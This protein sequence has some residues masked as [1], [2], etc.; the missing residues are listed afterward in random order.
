MLEELST[1]ASGA[2]AG[3]SRHS[4]ITSRLNTVAEPWLDKVLSYLPDGCVTCSIA[5]QRPGA[6]GRAAAEGAADDDAA[7]VACGDGGLLVCRC[8]RGQ[9]PVMAVLHPADSDKDNRYV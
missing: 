4:A 5:Q 7:A 3:G 1:A 8:S 6:G 2:D 9:P